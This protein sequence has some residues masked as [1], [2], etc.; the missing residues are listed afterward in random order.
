[1]QV[2]GRDAQM[3]RTLNGV[4]S[5]R[6]QRARKARGD[7]RARY[8]RHSAVG[9]TAA[10]DCAVCGRGGRRTKTHVPPRA[11][12]NRADLSMRRGWGTVDGK[13]EFGR[14]QSGGIWLFGH[15]QP[16]NQA[17]GAFD[18]AYR[19][20][21]DVVRPGIP[22][23]LVAPAGYRWAPTNT[24]IRPGAIARSVLSGM[25]ALNPTLRERYPDLALMLGDKT[26]PPVELPHDVRLRLAAH[27]GTRARVTGSY[28][29]WYLRLEGGQRSDGVM[30]AASVLFPPL[31]WHLAFP[32]VPEAEGPTVFRPLLDIEGWADVSDWV[33]LPVDHRQS[34]ARAIGAALPLVDL[35]EAHPID[36]WRWTWL[37]NSDICPILDADVT[38]A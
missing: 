16:C 27:A 1:M 13:L 4:V 30:T 28:G 17:A 37:L 10:G 33:R 24:A 38:L 6:A 23:G 11:A 9:Q 15:C 22:R 14:P 36:G 29:G 31:A 20:F 5:R 3:I 26:A 7:Q 32:D 8:V 35:P 18:D 34:T 2:P 12:G 19:D 25:F 21:A